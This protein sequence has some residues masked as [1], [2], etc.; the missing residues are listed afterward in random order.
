MSSFVL[1][2]FHHSRSL[3]TKGAT[4]ASTMNSLGD[5]TFLFIVSSHLLGSCGSML[6]VFGCALSSSSVLL[7][8]T[9]M[10]IATASSKGVQ[11]LFQIWL[12]DAM[13][14]P[15][16]ISALIHSST[17]V[18][19]GSVLLLKSTFCTLISSTDVLMLASG[20]SLISIVLVSTTVLLHN[21]CKRTIAS[22]T[23]VHVSLLL[24]FSSW[25]SGAV[26][27]HICSHSMFKATSFVACGL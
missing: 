4:K 3:A 9:V 1:V 24:L 6:V 5:A 10:V 17:L 7:W 13:E 16:P 27:C 2:G 19:S 22:S 23:A 15:T 12:E 25:I 21:D 18:V 20:C 8:T 11:C 14:G 26:L